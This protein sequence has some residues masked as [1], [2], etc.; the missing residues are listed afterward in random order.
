MSH[1]HGK[2][3][4]TTPILNYCNAVWLLS[5]QTISSAKHGLRP[6]SMKT[7]FF[8]RFCIVHACMYN[9]YCTCKMILVNPVNFYFHNEYNCFLMEKQVHFS[10]RENSMSN[11]A[12]LTDNISSSIH[13][14]GSRPLYNCSK[15][16]SAKQE[17]S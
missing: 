8:A 1:T 16:R 5:F 9:R 3:R 17:N 2:L 11:H 12:Y 4:I 15:Q 14:S 13:Y 10:R 6:H 7:E